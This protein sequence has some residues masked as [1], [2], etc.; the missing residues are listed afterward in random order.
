M[1]PRFHVSR[2]RPNFQTD[3]FTKRLAQSYGTNRLVTAPMPAL[4]L[5]AG[6]PAVVGLRY[7]PVEI[8][9]VLLTVDSGPTNAKVQVAA[10]AAVMF[11]PL[12][13]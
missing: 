7:H 5:N 13:R 4:K 6:A 11:P 10:V 2:P 1:G 8:P 12:T 9:P 3:A